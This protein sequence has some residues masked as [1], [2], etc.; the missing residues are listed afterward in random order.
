[1]GQLTVNL[2]ALLLVFFGAVL[3]FEEPINAVQMLWVN[4]VMDTF[5]ALALGTE[6]PIQELL[7]R[8]PYKRTASLISVPMRRNIVVQSAFQL[9]VLFFLMASPGSVGV[10][11]GEQCFTYGQGSGN[12]MY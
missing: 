12:T 7:E 9:A 3:G 6:P 8:K 5:G 10:V 4:L 2:V 1:M 11:G